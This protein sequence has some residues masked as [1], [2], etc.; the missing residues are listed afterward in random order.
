MADGSVKIDILAD[1]SDFKSKLSSLSAE[2][3]SAL[4][5]TGSSLITAGKAI[6]GAVTAPLMAA[7]VAAGKWGIGVASAAEQAEIAMTTMLGSSETA[8]S[9]LEQLADF[10]KST[11]FGLSGLT[12]ATQKLLA[13]GFEADRVIPL[14]TAVGDAT[15]GLGA[16]QQGIDQITRALGQMKAKGKVAAQEMMQLTE[17]GVPAWQMLADVVSNGDVARAMKMVTDGA[18]DAD[19]AIQALQDGMNKE[20]GG[21]MAKQALT[22]TGVLSNMG[23]A[24][25]GV[26]RKVYKTEAW[27]NLTKALSNVSDQLG[28]FVEKLMPHAEKLIQAIAGRVQQFADTLASLDQGDV[29]AIV[30]TLKALAA[31]GP[32]LIIMGKSLKTMSK[33]IKPLTKGFGVVGGAVNSAGKAVSSKFGPM[34]CK[35]MK[36]AAFYLEY[37]YVTAKD[38]AKNMGSKAVSGLKSFAKSTGTLLSKCFNSFIQGGG[39]TGLLIKSVSATPAAIS[40][41]MSKAVDAIKGV[42]ASIKTGFGNAVSAVK[43]FPA[44]IKGGLSKAASGVKAGMGA[45]QKVFSKDNITSA[46]SGLAGRIKGGL[47]NISTMWMQGGVPAFER[48]GWIKL[49]GLI[50]GVATGLG[51]GFAAM[52]GA[53]A[54]GLKSIN[55]STGGLLAKI[56]GGF[57]SFGA[58]LKG[59]L[60]SAITGAKDLVVKGVEGIKKSAV[61]LGKVGLQGGKSIA[62]GMGVA[63]ASVAALA[64]A[65]GG[66]LL[67]AA[68]TGTD[69]NALADNARGYIANVQKVALGTIS[70][71]SAA[72]PKVVS[73]LQNQAPMIVAQ[74]LE[75]AKSVLAALMD[76]LPQFGEVF[77]AALPIITQALTG[78][79]PMIVQVA[80]ILFTGLITGL[81]Q[82]VTALTAALPDIFTGVGEVLMEQGPDIFAAAEQLFMA[83]VNAIPVI[84]DLLIQGLPGFL[85]MVFAVLPGLVGTLLQAAVTLFTALVDAVPKVIPMLIR[86]VGDLIGDVITNLPTYIP[87]FISGAF[88][89]L[90]SMVDGIVQAVPEIVSAV[91]DM[92]NSAVDTIKNTDWI[93]VG[94]SIIDGLAKGITAFGGRILDGL[95]GIINGA[96]DTVK[97]WLG[98]HSPSRVFRKIG[99]YTGEGLAI[100]INDTQ[101]SVM[102]AMANL[103]D[104]VISEGNRISSPDISANLNRNITASATVSTNGVFA[105]LSGRIDAMSERLESALSQPVD[106][107]YNGR[108]FGRMVREVVPAR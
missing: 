84:I 105:S 85:Q 79:L 97:G 76:F 62:M 6:T 13:Y 36:D 70:G 80:I 18:V 51:S 42:G 60:S 16:G 12:T 46:L 15:A 14:L 55:Q 54:G 65:L 5:K 102:R 29:D 63:A 95:G 72:V 43:S 83:L 1:I 75:A 33:F 91:G 24:I 57:T 69:L 71:L 106:I 103:T 17:T 50:T 104:G 100:G 40:G 31:T 20:Y 23:D 90:K 28:P 87:Q 35:G 94:K 61:S 38:W 19:T 77:S 86:A 59:G 52:K 73:F 98:I 47:Y 88:D 2:A 78:L 27:G 41:A 64:V 67:A 37:G 89:L 68:A 108:E 48:A 58:T 93:E 53:V 10:A 32:A 30:G 7:T 101:K 49:K 4:D 11:P 92:I 44:A 3:S 8:Q 74:A 45:I 25:E 82:A 39:F 99:N 56:Q 107:N 22:L 81:A 21:L 26:V 34:I 9:M 96:V 66:T